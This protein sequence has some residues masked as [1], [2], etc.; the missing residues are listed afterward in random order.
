[1][2]SDITGPTA[3]RMKSIIFLVVAEVDDLCKKE[4][5]KRLDG[6]RIG[7]GQSWGVRVEMRVGLTTG[8]Y[9]LHQAACYHS[10]G[11]LQ[12][13]EDT[14]T[15][16]TCS[17]LPKGRWKHALN[18]SVDKVITVGRTLLFYL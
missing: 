2:Y 13:R 12:L 3:A 14:C 5:Q 10:S 9:P 18:F 4:N 17:L 11:N 15:A 6:R 1:M 7:N 8:L 16:R